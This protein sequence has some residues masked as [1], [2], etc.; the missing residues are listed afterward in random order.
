[1]RTLTLDCDFTTNSC[2]S[3]LFRV[4]KIGSLKII[5]LNLWHSEALNALPKYCL[6]YN[7]R[8]QSENATNSNT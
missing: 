2:Q 8:D 3:K 4:K 5:L 6:A 7:A 1:M